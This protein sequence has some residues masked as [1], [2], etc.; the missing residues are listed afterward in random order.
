M[1]RSLLRLLEGFANHRTGQT[2]NGIAHGVCV[3]KGGDAAML[4]RCRALTT[5]W[6]LGDESRPPGRFRTWR[7]LREVIASLDPDVVHARTTAVW[8]DAALATRRQN[9]TRLLLSFHGRT[10]L[11]LPS[12][13]RRRIHRW[14]C[15]QA[16]AVMT[17]SREAASM[18][19]QEWRVAGDKIHVVPNGVD[20]NLFRPPDP[21]RGDDRPDLTVR[22]SADHVV[23]CVAN[24]VE[25][26]AIDLL[27]NNWRRV[28]MADPRARLWLVGDGPLHAPLT[29][30]ANDLRIADTVQFLGRR[31][32][33]PQLLRVADL[34]VLPSRYEASPN[35]IL[36][37]MAT[38]LPVVAFDVGGIRELVRPHHTGWLV[39]ADSPERLADT[40]LA[41]LFD[42]SARQ[43]IGQT[44]RR[45]IVEEHNL[46]GW[47][48]R[49]A[50][51]YHRLVEGDS[52][53]CV[54]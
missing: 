48:D 54:A 9:H 51:L 12:W 42:R 49:Y 31:D 38:A 7:R 29:R 26:K 40:I 53:A 13:L 24:L 17:V 20:A 35:A 34:F 21:G 43:R 2:T 25:I 4:G 27:L 44:A 15:Q 37:A 36:E 50:E 32:D 10:N 39:P 19:Q 18:L 16:D 46:D 14:A 5:T 23:I 3:L 22:G 52:P 8:L 1:E 45:A 28:V 11:A 6:V 41:A 30:L 47:V 33:V